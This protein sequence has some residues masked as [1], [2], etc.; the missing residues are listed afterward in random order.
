MDTEMIRCTELQREQQSLIDM[1]RASLAEFNAKA[2]AARGKILLNQNIITDAENEL[3][4][5]HS[6]LEEHNNKCK[7][8]RDSIMVQLS[9]AH[10]DQEAM[11]LMVASTDCGG[12]LLQFTCQQQ[13]GTPVVD[14]RHPALKRKVS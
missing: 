2:A 12:A 5:L 9:T 4:K 7:E 3:P 14:F 1:A 8:V 13:G 6:A 10:E 11:R